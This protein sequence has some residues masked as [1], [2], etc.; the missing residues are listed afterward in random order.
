MRKK[1]RTQGRSRHGYGVGAIFGVPLMVT[2][3]FFSPSVPAASAA[4]THVFQETFGSAAQPTFSQIG[5]LAVDQGTGDVLVIDSVALTVSRFKSNGEPDPFSALGTNV[6]DAKGVIPPAKCTPPSPECD[7]TP[8]QG[9][10]FDSTFVEQQIAVDSSGSVTDGNIYV[11]QGSSGAGVNLVDV[12]AGTGEYLGQITAA[13]GVPFGEN[14][15]KVSPTGVT[16]DSDGAI[17]VAGAFDNRI[18]KFVPSANPPVNADW[19][20]SFSTVTKPFSIAAGAGPTAN[21]LFVTEQSNRTFKINADTGAVEALVNENDDQVVAVDSSSSNSEGHVFAAG[22]ARPRIREYEVLGATPTLVSNFDEG[23]LNDSGGLAIGSGGEVYVSVGL[24]GVSGL[25]VYTPLVFPPIPVTGAA[26]VRDNI[27]VTMTGTVNPEGQPLEECYFEYGPTSAYGAVAACE[28]PDTTEVEGVAPVAVHADL[29]GLDEEA[30]YH[31]RLVAKNAVETVKGQD[32]TVKTPSIPRVVAEWTSSVDTNT[33]TLKATINPEND[34]TSFFV[35]WGISASYGHRT[36]ARTVAIGRDQE[37]HLVSVDLQGL[38]TGA[39]YH[40]HIIATNSHGTVEGADRNFTTFVPGRGLLADERVYELVS[41]QD[42]NNAEVGLPEAA[43][44]GAGK[45]DIGFANPQQAA[46]SGGAISFH[47][48][49]AFGN[50]PQSAPISSQYLSSA[51]QATVPSWS[52]QNIDPPFEEGYLRNPIVGLSADLSHAIA[53]VIAPALAGAP[54]GFANIYLRDN[55]TG[56]L[57]ALSTSVPITDLTGGERF[58]VSYGGASTNFKRIFF[59]ARGALISGDPVANGFNLYEWTVF[60]GLHLVSRLPTE[61]P[62]TPSLATGFGSP[63]GGPQCKSSRTFLRHAVSADGSRVFW[64]YDG[65]FAGAS[66]PLFARVD[67]FET[68]QLDAKQGGTGRGGGRYWDAS[69]DGSKVFFTDANRLTAASSTT[70]SDLYVY[71]LDKW[72]DN[73][74]NPLSDLTPVIGEGANV[75]GVLGASSDGAFVYYVATGRVTG[76][77]VNARHEKAMAGKPN[78][79]VWHEGSGNR[80][81]ATLDG[82][83]DTNWSQ[84]PTQQAA[85]V[86]P[87]GRH[88]AFLS[89]AALTGY[90]NTVD[91]GSSC[92]RDVKQKALG[93]KCQ[94]AY[95]YDFVANDLVCVSCNPANSRPLGT[96]SFPVWSSPETQPRYLSDRGDRVYFQTPDPLIVADGNGQQDVYQWEREGTGSCT[97]SSPSFHARNGGCIDLVSSGQSPQGSYFVDASS[98]G[99]DVFFAT[100]QRLVRSDRDQ[101]FDVYDAR[102]GGSVEPPPPPQCEGEGCRGQGTTPAAGQTPGTADFVGPG[103]PKPKAC[104]KGMRKVRQK[105]RRGKPKKARCVRAKTRKHRQQKRQAHHRRGVNR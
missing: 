78:L 73:R 49:T 101:R 41:P 90:D 18:Y 97:G 91:S 60:D 2:V 9:F 39:T 45:T 13:N 76:E 55:R 72:E 19:V 29:N 64:T 24:G 8:Q 6:L 96:T 95:V 86:A 75:Q 43:G 103:N 98:S 32:A 68:V 71:D 46:P 70:G 87:D 105:G 58:C 20:A 94:E 93:P 89:T 69:L 44:T 31:Y 63:D 83:D 77:A 38:A 81:I 85:R 61:V 65:T 59:V 74:P 67:G 11:T 22:S 28:D 88:V 48:A 12:F 16:V 34:E 14:L 23:Y 4:G 30:E 53:V 10:A 102:V 40:W 50:A 26:I 25:Q 56:S 51:S 35:E 3:L 100:R 27:S 79:Y 7:G 15:F 42:K 99:D 82:G 1:R 54:E 66:D 21:S 47:S 17:Y 104:R 52:T 62:A 37:N 92:G 36:A 33:A 84:N 80:F 5:G 57:R